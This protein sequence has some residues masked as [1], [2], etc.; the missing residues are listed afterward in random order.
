MR[1]GYVEGKE[2]K[3]TEKQRKDLMRRFDPGRI[4]KRK[5]F[6]MDVYQIRGVCNFCGGCENCSL[7]HLFK[8]GN[9]STVVRKIAGRRCLE[10]INFG[11]DRIW[12]DVYHDRSVRRGISKIYLA[13]LKMEKI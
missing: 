12:W 10:N 2:I 1:I 11:E 8:K 9:C 3:F 7:F 5:G 6:W 13:L 4:E